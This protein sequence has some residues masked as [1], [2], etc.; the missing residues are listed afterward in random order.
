MTTPAFIS[1]ADYTPAGP[2]VYFRRDFPVAADLVRATVKVTALGIVVPRLNGSRIGD[3]VLAPGWTSYTHRVHVSE[4][5][6][7]DLIEQGANTFAAIVGEGWAV[8]PL[9]WEL[10]RENYIDRPALWTEITLHYPDRVEVIGSDDSFHVGQGA[11]RENGIYAGETFDARLEPAGWDRPGFTVDNWSPAVLVPWDLDTLQVT[12][13]PPVRRIEELAPV[14]ISTTP[15]GASIIDFGQL[16]SGWVR[17][18]VDG[19]AGTT[20]TL[21]HAELLTPAGELEAETLRQAAA[22]DTFILAGT[23]QEAWEPQFTF[24]GFR[25]VQI[26]GW[27]GDLQ[28]DAIRAVV[29]HTD[30]TRTG[31]FD[32]SDPLVSKLH[33]NTVWAMRGNFVSVPTDC[34]QRDERLGWT[35]DLNAFAPTANYLYDTRGILTSWLQDLAAEQFASG[36]VPWVVP[37]V[38]PTSSSPTSVWSDVAVSLPWELYQEYADL[39]ILRASYESMATFIRQVEGLLDDSG[40]W[41]DGF[42]FGDWLDPDAPANNPAGGKTDRYL[43]ANA[44]LCK[45]T[46]EMTQTARLLGHTEDAEH[47]A[48]LHD[49]V[50]TAFHREYVTASG[51]VVNES[52]T[53]YALA[54]VFD[55]LTDTQKQKAGERLAEIVEATGYTIST[56][57]AGT[58]L[59]SDAL[60]S[61]GHLDAAY[62]L[63]LEQQCPSFLYPVIMGATTIWERWD[64]VLPDGTVNATGMTS[65]NHYALG[66]VA[67]WLH[68]VVGGLSKL[69]PGWKRILI[70][71]Q[72]GG[73]LMWARTSHITPLGRAEV[74][75]QVKDG[76][77]VLDVTIPEGAAATVVLPLHPDGATEEVTAGTHA[78]RYPAPVGY[79]QRAPFTM[80]T[81]LK[82]IAADPDVWAQ[83][84]EVFKIYFPGVPIDAAG[85]HLAAMPLS[86]VLER[87]PGGDTSEISRDL[88]A[89]IAPHEATLDRTEIPV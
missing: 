89:A 1:T 85:S 24:H 33:E 86:A 7:T 15:S 71:P 3:E 48:A 28:P 2:A 39:D 36:D 81:P 8:G 11:V 5:D 25:Y 42:Q 17:L 56:G 51:R 20:I 79:G 70:A 84:V 21:R 64:S 12:S 4:Y 62:K 45:T 66:A 19:P 75:W 52:A 14:T 38:L 6:I 78:W 49:R 77:V 74:S 30:M 29:V 72:P 44:Y 23:G 18:T 32:T 40:L 31:W 22:T 27:P 88:H 43:V 35:G 68:R 16:L 65:L 9:T 76:E 46:R 53:A 10:N 41:S 58:P 57:F 69:E 60:S 61:T 50:L 37:D 82:E 83:V 54:I 13:A 80:D 87:F 26:G 55:I 34:P 59:V 47:F 73:A 63:L 67:S